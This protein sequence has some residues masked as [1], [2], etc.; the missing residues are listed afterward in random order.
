MKPAVIKII[1]GFLMFIVGI[2]CRDSSDY[3]SFCAFVI[4]YLILGLDIII[5]SFKNMMRGK[6]F[7]ENL[8]MFIATVGTFILKKYP[9]GVEVMLF[10]QIGE[11]FNDYAV[12]KS[13]RSVEKLLDIRPDCA[14][15]MV[16]NKFSKISAKDVHCGDTIMIKPGERVPLDCTVKDGNSTVDNSVITGESIPQDVAAGSELLSGC[17]NLSGVVI[18]TV[19]AEYEESAA[20]RILSLVKDAADKK[21]HTENFITEFAKYYTPAIIIASLVISIVPPLFIPGASF[22]TWIYRALIFLV[23]SC[24]CALVIS[25]PL[26]FFC[27]IGA[28]SKRG[29]LIKGSNYIEGLATADTV[30]FDKTGTLTKGSFSVTKVVPVGIDKDKFLETASYAEI[31]SSHPIALSIKKIFDKDLDENRVEHTEN[32]SGQGIKAIVDG[33][34]VL[35]GN[36]KLMRAGEIDFCPTHHVGS[37]VY[38]AIDGVYC[39]YLIISDRIKDDALSGIK[40]L[41]QLGI[42][43]TAML[44]GD[45]GEVGKSVADDLGLDYIAAELSP[46]E[47]VEEIYKLEGSL[48]SKGTLI[49]V[50]DGI[51][52]APV[53]ASADVGVAM[54][55]I[56]ADAAVE[57]ADVVII[58]DKP[59][60]VADAVSL[61]KFTVNIAKQNI[62]F[63]LG[64]KLIILLMGALGLSSI[65]EAVFSDVGVSMI[66][67]LNSL[68]V[69]KR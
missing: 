65:G 59:S 62:V 25:V 68:R 14:N 51:N 11:L 22:E 5:K 4:S 13:K 69:L 40:R 21:A 44:T 47:K 57:T 8:L 19:K 48:K 50:G 2:A 39:G 31:H 43:R 27:G 33:K 49:F 17:I 16:N 55:G 28:A 52:D 66:V 7:D 60:K 63:S 53:I 35:L 10:Y 9:E 30:V 41:Y 38:M 12:E 6:I 1:A 61:S 58:D 24:P 32:I 18:A 42:E 46:E 37:V 64:V 45:S 26:S 29:L 3:I 36:S 20:S 34:T 67:I 15:V 56:G 23:I 54:G